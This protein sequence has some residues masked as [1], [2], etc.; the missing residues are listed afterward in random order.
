[1]V[2]KR[3]SRTGVDASGILTSTYV[4]MPTY[5]LK[6]VASHQLTDLTLEIEHITTCR[7][8]IFMIYVLILHFFTVVLTALITI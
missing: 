5:F 3:K 2:H 4:T 7:T 1:M 6:L 8:Y